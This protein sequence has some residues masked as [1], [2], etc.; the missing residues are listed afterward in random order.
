MPFQHFG[1]AVLLIVLTSLIHRAGTLL[2]FWRLFRSRK[3][4]ARH[5]GSVLNA[6]RLTL[7][8]LALLAVYLAEA[9]CWAAF[10]PTKGVSP[11]STSPYFSM[12]TYTTVRY[13]DVVLRD[14]EWRLLGGVE[15]LTGSL[16]LSWSTVI[17][18]QVI[19]KIYQQRREIWEEKESLA[20][21]RIHHTDRGR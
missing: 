21:E 20:C 1:S 2:I 8:V 3:L 12:I 9:I 14:K 6:T 11:A 10:F 15:A 13:G 18:V 16:M 7:V 5:F 4:A 17:L 19:T